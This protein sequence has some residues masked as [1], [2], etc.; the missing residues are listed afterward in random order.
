MDTFSR[1]GSSM[2]FIYSG[3]CALVNVASL[4]SITEYHLQFGVSLEKEFNY[5]NGT[6][7]IVYGNLNTV[8]DSEGL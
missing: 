4:K 2:N 6:L 3:L 5:F 8:F 7:L 1:T